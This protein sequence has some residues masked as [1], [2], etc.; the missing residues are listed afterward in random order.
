MYGVC[1]AGSLREATH[2]AL[3]ISRSIEYLLATGNLVSKTG[4]GLQQVRMYSYPIVTLTLYPVELSD[5]EYIVVGVRLC[6][7][8]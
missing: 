2:H 8:G 1:H 4:L 7:G 3:D 6:G 5:G